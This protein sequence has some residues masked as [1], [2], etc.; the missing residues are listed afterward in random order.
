MSEFTYELPNEED[1]FSALIDYLNYENQTEIVKLLKKCDISFQKTSTFTEKVW[2]TFWCSINLYTSI[3]ELPTITEE[4]K[5]NLKNYCSKLLPSNCGYLIKGIEFIPRI[6]QSSIEEPPE[7]EVVFEQQ[8]NRIIEHLNQAKFLIWIAVAWFT[9][10]EIYDLL[11]QKGKEGLSIRII[12]S[13][14][15]KNLKK[16]EKYKKYLNINLYPK[17]GIY[18]YNIMHNKF[19]IIDLKEVIHGSYNWSK[20]A[21]YNKETVEIIENRKTA[22]A[23]AEEFKKL[24][25]EI[26]ENKHSD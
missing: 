19:C 8:K 25:K 22:E 2:D 13:E 26:I 16:Y 12:I 23:Y 4:T 24:V 15:E 10:E 14:D 7:I 6:G 11:V 18:N 20:T 17:F 21:E 9:L 1:F 5:E 3:S